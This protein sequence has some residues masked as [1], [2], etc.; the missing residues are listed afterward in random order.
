[1]R[2]QPWANSFKT[3][4]FSNNN[5]FKKKFEN[6]FETKKKKKKIKLQSV[7]EGSDKM[8]GLLEQVRKYFK[9]VS[10]IC[11][12]VQFWEYW[13]QRLKSMFFYKICILETERSKKWRKHLKKNVDFS[14]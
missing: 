1:M 3:F 13:P 7:S 2:G 5:N 12:K 11:K 8:T 10:K 6:S 9:N 14:L 4:L